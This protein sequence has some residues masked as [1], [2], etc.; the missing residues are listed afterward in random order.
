MF[1]YLKSLPNLFPADYKNNEFKWG[2]LHTECEKH[3]KDMT[4]LYPAK[5]HHKIYGDMSIVHRFLHLW[6]HPASA[7]MRSLVFKLLS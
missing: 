4:T 5:G 6:E 2:D 7:R 3:F 1:N